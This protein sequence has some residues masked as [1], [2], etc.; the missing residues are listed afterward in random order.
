MDSALENNTTPGFVDVRQTL[1]FIDDG[2]LREI[3]ASVQTMQN[4]IHQAREGIVVNL[5]QLLYEEILAQLGDQVLRDAQNTKK[6]DEPWPRHLLRGLMIQSGT[7]TCQHREE[8]TGVDTEELRALSGAYCCKQC[9][10]KENLCD[11]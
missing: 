1:C 3:D 4:V 11:V 6:D 8:R 10:S 9:E 7:S 2:S 5:I